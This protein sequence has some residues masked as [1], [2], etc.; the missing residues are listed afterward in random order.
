MKPLGKSQRCFCRW[1]P[2]HLGQVPDPYAPATDT[3]GTD[4]AETL[5]QLACR[6]HLEAFGPSGKE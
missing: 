2:K 3:K 6:L 1:Y 4:L 5:H